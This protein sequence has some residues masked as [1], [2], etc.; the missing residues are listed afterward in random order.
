MGRLDLEGKKNKILRQILYF[1]CLLQACAKKCLFAKPESDS[2]L[3]VIMDISGKKNVRFDWPGLV[4]GA[5]YELELR[6]KEHGGAVSISS[7]ATMFVT[8][9]VVVCI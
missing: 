6:Q 5:W 4:V 8:D 2:G 1:I 7:A 3:L 9:Y